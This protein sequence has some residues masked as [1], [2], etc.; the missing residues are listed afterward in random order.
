M[1]SV[2]CDNVLS[3]DILA[4]AEAKMWASIPRPNNSTLFSALE[5]RPGL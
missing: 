3:L 5:V 1:V 4:L 2:S